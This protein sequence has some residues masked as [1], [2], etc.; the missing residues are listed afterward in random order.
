MMLQQII[1][2]K[3]KMLLRIF[4]GI[5]PTVIEKEWRH[6]FKVNEEDKSTVATILGRT[7]K[8]SGKNKSWYNVRN[9]KTGKDRSVDLEKVREWRK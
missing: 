9:H 7:G 6:L 4:P 3:R 2:W 1:G 8:S 5:I